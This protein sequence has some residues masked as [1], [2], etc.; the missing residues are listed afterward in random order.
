MKFVSVC[1][2]F[3]SHHALGACDGCHRGRLSNLGHLVLE[4]SFSG[5]IPT[6]MYVGLVLLDSLIAVMPVKIASVS[7]FDTW[8]RQNVFPV[9]TAHVLCNF[10]SRVLDSHLQWISF[11]FVFPFAEGL[12]RGDNPHGNVRLFYFL[13]PDS[14]VGQE[15]KAAPTTTA[16]VFCNLFFALK[17][18]LF[19]FE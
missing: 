8:I 5:T 10:V 2:Y 12:F 16:H 6:E 14:Q 19:L 4:G 18:P 11:Q 9:A 1:I 3:A 17:L 15:G 7:Y 13:S